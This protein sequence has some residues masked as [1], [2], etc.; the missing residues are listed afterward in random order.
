[1]DTA[2]AVILVIVACAVGGALLF[3]LRQGPRNR[4][5]L[6]AFADSQGWHFA[7][8]P[9]S[10]GRGSQIIV[11]DPVEGWKFVQHVTPSGSQGG[12]GRRWVQF[13]QPRLALDDGMALLGPTLPAETAAL[14]ERLLTQ[15]GTGGTIAQ[16]LLNK[17]TGGLG[18]EAANLRAVPGDQPGT[19]FATP[20]RETA[21]DVLRD[22]PELAQSR[23]NRSESDQ[24][25]VLRSRVGFCLRQTGHLKRADEVQR[26]I[27]L[28][29]GLSDRLSG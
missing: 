21:L 7:H 12:S 4:R 17:I 14:T 11:S 20:G 26:F 2:V 28:G 24:P 6:R 18:P 10:G 16:M 9:S 19:L 3:A 25:I 27:A 1:M 8:H 22:A 13:E 5:K 15:V 29:K 23:Q